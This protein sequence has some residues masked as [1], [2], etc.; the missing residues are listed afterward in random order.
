[1]DL[2]RQSTALGRGEVWAKQAQEGKDHNLPGKAEFALFFGRF[3]GA[4][5]RNPA[6][7]ATTI[8]HQT[9]GKRQRSD[10]RTYNATHLRRTTAVSCGRSGSS[11]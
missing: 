8:A 10:Y 3:A 6:T 7:V 4:L 11:H 1:M 9:G 5:D 2:K